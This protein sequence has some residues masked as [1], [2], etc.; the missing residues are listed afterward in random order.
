MTPERRAEL[1]N[2]FRGAQHSVAW[3]LLDALDAAEAREA[4]AFERGARSCVHRF[5][6]DEDRSQYDCSKCGLGVTSE[7]AQAAEKGTPPLPPLTAAEEARL[8]ASLEAA[9]GEVPRPDPLRD[10][11]EAEDKVVRDAIVDD[12]HKAQE[13]PWASGPS[14][15]AR[16]A[17]RAFLAKRRGTTP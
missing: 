14:N 10:P 13:T 11:S 7:A 9:K 1:R 4:G 3:E 6:F 2:A 8:D 17:I 5:V 16:V 12:V 15:I